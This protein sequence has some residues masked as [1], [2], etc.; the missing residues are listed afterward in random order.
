MSGRG[1][2]DCPSSELFFD[3]SLKTS[4]QSWIIRTDDGVTVKESD[5]LGVGHLDQPI[6]PPQLKLQS[7]HHAEVV[8]LPILE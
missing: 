2:A 5:R 4:A 8:K 3:R 7:S 1:H 6:P